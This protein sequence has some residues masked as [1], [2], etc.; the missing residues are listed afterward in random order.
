MLHR[1]QFHDILFR[2]VP[3]DVGMHTTKRLVSYSDP[4]DV[5][6]PVCL[7]FADGTEA[8]CDIL[9]GADGFRSAVRATLFTNLANI[10]E[11]VNTANRRRECVPP[12]FSGATLYRTVIPREKLSQLSADYTGWNM[13]RIVRHRS[14]ATL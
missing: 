6:L 9:I 10:T 1:A 2:H 8:E 11:D 14:Y 4:E 13:G 7:V 3:K 5:N 12:R